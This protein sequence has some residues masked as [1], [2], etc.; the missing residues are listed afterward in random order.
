MNWKVWK[1]WLGIIFIIAMIIA[2]PLSERLTYKEI[3]IKIQE[4]ERVVEKSG[5]SIES[6]YIVFCEDEVFQNT[7]SFWMFK[8]NSSDIQRDL[9]IGGTY[10]VGVNMWRIRLFSRYRNII[11]IIKV[12]EN[13]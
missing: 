7:D 11:K 3:K 12:I 13:N 10:L 5:K 2:I 6:R 1:I 4:K 9:K 8:F